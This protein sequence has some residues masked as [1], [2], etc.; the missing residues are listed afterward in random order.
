MLPHEPSRTD[1]EQKANS[2]MKLRK[3]VNILEP[4]LSYQ[5]LGSLFQVRKDYGLGQKESIYKKA[6]KEELKSRGLEV[7]E[8]KSIPV[9]SVKSKKP[10]GWYRPDLIVENRIV[11][12]LEI[13]PHSYSQEHIKRTYDYLRNSEYEIAYLA[14]FGRSKMT[15]KRIIFPNEKKYIREQS[16]TDSEHHTNNS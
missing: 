8:E 15:Y 2:N 5:V 7:E 16:R 1:N 6:L 4:K 3:N 14:N 11:I 10:I 13:Y 12:E 9:L